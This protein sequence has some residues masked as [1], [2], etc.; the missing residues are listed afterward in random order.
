VRHGIYC[1]KSRQYDRMP[2]M[3]DDGWPNVMTG[4][5]NYANKGFHDNHAICS[6]LCLTSLTTSPAHSSVLCS[7]PA[8]G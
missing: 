8:R 6:L 1:E 4:T 3:T 2:K 7:R 5:A